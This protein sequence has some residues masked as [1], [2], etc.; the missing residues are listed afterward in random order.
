[1]GK[2][3]WTY[4][5]IVCDKKGKTVWQNGKLCVTKWEKLCEP[6][7]TKPVKSRLSELRHYIDIIW[8]LYRHLLF[9]QIIGAQSPPLAPASLLKE[10]SPVRF[11]CELWRVSGT[12]NKGR[13]YH[14][15]LAQVLRRSFNQRSLRFSI[16]GGD[17]APLF[18]FF[19]FVFII[20][21]QDIK[22]SVIN[23]FQYLFGRL[24]NHWHFHIHH[25]FYTVSV[26]HTKRPR[27]GRQ[28]C[29]RQLRR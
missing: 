14:Q 18:V 8:I 19:L 10:K 9:G 28:V 15:A 22:Y 26:G 24:N 20:I 7:P 6:I 3:V 11:R 2:C 16:L 13:A 1:M 25:P 5:E 27:Y 17:W 12:D 21:I 23:V 29:C 4:G